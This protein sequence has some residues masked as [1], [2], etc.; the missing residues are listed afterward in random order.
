MSWKRPLATYGTDSQATLPFL[1]HDSLLNA[2][3]RPFVLPDHGLESAGRLNTTC[4]RFLAIRKNP[5]IRSR[6]KGMILEGR[7]YPKKRVIVASPPRQH[8]GELEGVAT[9]SFTIGRRRLRGS[10]LPNQVTKVDGYVT[11]A[12]LEPEVRPARGGRYHPQETDLRPHRRSVPCSAS[13]PPAAIP[14][15][16]WAGPAPPTAPIVPGTAAAL[17]SD[18][19]LLP[20]FSSRSRAALAYRALWRELED[21]IFERGG[22]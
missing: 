5:V 16:R 20:A 21:L 18:A 4:Q 6:L 10:L 11:D 17:F 3:E 22:G 1:D 14:V 19:A 13:D 9:A 12:P 7:L 2:A 15:V 8:S